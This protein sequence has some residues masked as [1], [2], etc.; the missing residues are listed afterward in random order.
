MKNL[1]KFYKKNTSIFS[2]Y[3]EESWFL[4]KLLFVESLRDPF[5]YSLSVVRFTCHSHTTA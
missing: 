3:K 2:V 1:E 4:L 5:I